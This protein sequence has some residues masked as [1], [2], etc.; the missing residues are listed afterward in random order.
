MVQGIARQGCSNLRFLLL[1]EGMESSARRSNE[2]CVLW[3]CLGARWGDLLGDARGWGTE[4]A[5]VTQ[6]PIRWARGLGSQ[7][8]CP[9]RLVFQGLV[10]RDSNAICVHFVRSAQPLIS[11]LL[12]TILTSFLCLLAVLFLLFPNYFS[13]MS[14]FYSLQIHIFLFFF[15]FSFCTCN[16]WFLCLFAKLSLRV[17]VLMEGVIGILRD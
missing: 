8:H 13:K 15:S 16:F 14:V 6:V 4:E 10:S 7:T 12:E 3:Q 5:T 11:C 9:G 1:S 2:R 17:F